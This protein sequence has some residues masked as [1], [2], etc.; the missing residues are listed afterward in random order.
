[1]SKYTILILGAS[2]MQLPAIRSARSMGWQVLVADRNELAPGA[3]LCDL[4]LPVDIA[5]HEVVLKAITDGGLDIDGVFTAGTDFSATVAYVAEK[6]GIPGIPYEVALDASD[7]A[8]MRRVFHRFGLPSPLFRKVRNVGEAATVL[9]DLELPLVVKPVDNMGARG[10][11]RVDS[12]EDLEEAVGDALPYSRSASVIVESYLPGPE[13][14]LDALV[15]RGEIHLCGIA[16]RDI[17]FSPYFVETGHAMPSDRP[18]SMQ[19]RVIDL[20]FAGIRALGIENGAAKGDIKYGTDGPV[21]GEIAARLS[22][23]YMSGWT[24]PYSS[25]VD[26]TRA[27]LRIAVGLD[28][29]DLE[30]QRSHTSA[31][32]AFYSIPGT[33]QSIPG[34]ADDYYRPICDAFLRIDVG[35]SV[36]FPQNNVQKCGNVIATSPDRSAAIGAAVRRC[37]EVLVRLSRDDEKTRAFLD[38]Q[39]HPWVPDAFT[40]QNPANI[41]ALARMPTEASGEP[42]APDDLS[43]QPLPDIESERAT[44][45]QERTF[46]ETIRW[47][48]DTTGVAFGSSGRRILGSVFWRAVIRGGVQGGIW[49]VDT[50]R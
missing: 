37:N 50:H 31:E 9:D 33:V 27:A 17:R 25:G 22:G 35:D 2:T 48:S 41:D 32:R 13:F 15:Y 44:D 29:G 39:S 46:S 43:I 12:S 5:E 14:S 3:S 6:L 24:Y 1:M 34:F 7:K 45:W 10:V 28:P 8:R 23:G 36:D 11:R 16:D 47:I 4:F 49:L 26:V 19:R 40:L 38:G 21:I 18:E 20:F 30:P 42:D